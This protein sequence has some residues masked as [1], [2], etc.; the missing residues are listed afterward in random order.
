M[1]AGRT[2]ITTRR[3]RQKNVPQ[4]QLNLLTERLAE[5]MK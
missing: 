3:K 2:D 5:T 4:V 1:Q